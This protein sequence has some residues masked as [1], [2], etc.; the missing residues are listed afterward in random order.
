[1]LL[2]EDSNPSLVFQS[3]KRAKRKSS[4]IFLHHPLEYHAEHTLY[5]LNTCNPKMVI[6]SFFIFNFIQCILVLTTYLFIFMPYAELQ[7]L[8]CTLKLILCHL[9]CVQIKIFN[10]KPEKMW[11]FQNLVLSTLP[12]PKVFLVGFEPGTPRT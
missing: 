2:W 10:L 4:F 6:W 1:M 5:T 3:Q 8:I 11:N 7:R 9:N 12:K